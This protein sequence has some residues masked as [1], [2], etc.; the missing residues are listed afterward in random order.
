MK[1]IS[2]RKFKENCKHSQS[3]NVHKGD[4]KICIKGTKADGENYI[5]LLCKEKSCPVLRTCKNI[6]HYPFGNYYRVKE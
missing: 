3:F 1:I 5:F 6:E 2:F 4:L